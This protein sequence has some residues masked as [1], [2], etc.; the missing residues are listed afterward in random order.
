MHQE[1]LDSQTA[2]APNVPLTLRTADTGWLLLLLV[3]LFGCLPTFLLVTIA[4]DVDSNDELFLVLGLA[5]GYSLWNI[6][7]LLFLQ[8]KA[9][10][11]LDPQK[12]EIY[13]IRE[14][15]VGIGKL[16]RKRV[17]TW[18]P[19]EVVEVQLR[20]ALLKD[21]LIIK[22]NRKKIHPIVLSHKQKQQ[23]IRFI[24]TLQ[25][26]N[27]GLSVPDISSPGKQGPI[28][29]DAQKLQ[30]SVALAEKLLYIWGG[31]DLF[32]GF[33]SMLLV[34]A[35]IPMNLGLIHLGTGIAYLACGFGIR[36]H[37]EFAPWLAILVLLA[38]RS[39]AFFYIRTLGSAGTSQIFGWVISLLYLLILINSANSLRVL[40][41]QS[42][43]RAE[44]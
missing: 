40:R 32:S 5:V 37:V 44:E 9:Q 34:N 42:R 10:I 11:T 7:L 27:S 22:D 4:A 15:W 36:K 29:L 1:V 24:Q 8:R 2:Q 17:R 39:Y 31:F 30:Q 14:Y 13:L 28:A 3:F 16:G 41:Q 19:E 21:A 38:E 43:A 33:S 23:A 12:R 25:D 35:G 18:K 26:L 6:M 20:E